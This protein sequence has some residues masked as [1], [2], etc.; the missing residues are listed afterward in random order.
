MKKMDK[1]DDKLISKNEFVEFWTDL[2]LKQFVEEHQRQ[3]E[4]QL[5]ARKAVS[6]G[7]PNLSRASSVDLR[8]L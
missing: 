4:E 8:K 7:D 5:Q 3:K 2:L 6:G 1:N